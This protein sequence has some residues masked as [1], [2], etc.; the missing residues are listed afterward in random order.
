MWSRS[1]R[2]RRLIQQPVTSTCAH[3]LQEAQNEPRLRGNGPADPDKTRYRPHRGS[4]INPTLHFQ[5]Q[6]RQ[7]AT[8]VIMNEV[9]VV[10]VLVTTCCSALAQFMLFCL[11]SLDGSFALIRTLGSRCADQILS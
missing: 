10:C 3:F 11:N 7:N 2:N 8:E 9:N 5:K 4:M 1:K 6:T